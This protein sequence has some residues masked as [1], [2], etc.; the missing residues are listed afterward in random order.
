MAESCRMFSFSRYSQPVFQRACMLSV[1]HL[2]TLAVLV[3]AFFHFQKVFCLFFVPA[4]IACS[5]ACPKHWDWY[6]ELDPDLRN[7]S[8]KSDR[9]RKQ[10]I[11]FTMVR[12][13]IRVKCNGCIKE[14]S[15][16]SLEEMIKNM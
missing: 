16:S 4:N 9:E 6:K 8:V 14:D 12:D 13:L 5:K 15:T 7:L 11:E 3:C 2:Y 1:F 10:L